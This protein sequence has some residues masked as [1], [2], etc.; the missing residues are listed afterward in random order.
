M[1]RLADE[2]WGD[3]EAG[4]DGRRGFAFF[5]GSPDG[6]VTWREGN[7]ME[8][9]VAGGGVAGFLPLTIDEVDSRCGIG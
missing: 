2:G 1:F 4:G 9:M 3:V 6:G 5:K 7:P 8:D